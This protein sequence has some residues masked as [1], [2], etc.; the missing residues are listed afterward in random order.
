[1]PDRSVRLVDRSWPHVEGFE[2]P[3]PAAEEHRERYP[4]DGDRVA[5]MD[6]AVSVSPLSVSHENVDSAALAGLVDSIE[7]D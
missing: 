7:L 1:P 5:M 4:E 2:N 3:F 6:G